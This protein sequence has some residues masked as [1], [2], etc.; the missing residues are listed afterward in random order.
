MN[1]L[2]YYIDAVKDKIF[3]KNLYP[4]IFH[5]AAAYAFFIIKEHIF[6]DGNKR[7]G[8]AAAITFLE[9]NECSLKESVSNKDIVSLALSIENG[10]L[11]FERVVD[12]FKENTLTS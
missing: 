5:K 7:T 1:S 11:E 6:Y 2:E 9:R 12:W 10:T 8:L 4:T 3:G